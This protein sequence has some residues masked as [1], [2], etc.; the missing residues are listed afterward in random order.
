MIKYE[1]YKKMIYNRAWYLHNISG[2]EWEELVCIGN[3]AYIET[4]QRFRPDIG[5]SFSTYFYRFCHGRMLDF[6]KKQQI[7]ETTYIEEIPET[8]FLSQQPIVFDNMNTI[9]IIEKLSDSAKQIVFD[10]INDCSQFGF[11]KNDEPPRMIN[12]IKKVL[13][14]R[15]WENYQIEKTIQELSMVFQN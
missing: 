11:K 2:A 5:V 7:A 13:K 10:L 15:G 1:K 9:H 4:M 6:I 14:N 8:E 12:R 3:L